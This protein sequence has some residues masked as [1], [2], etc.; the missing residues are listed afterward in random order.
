MAQSKGTNFSSANTPS[1]GCCKHPSSH[2]TPSTTTKLLSF[3]H[4]T[5]ASIPTVIAAIPQ[6]SQ[7]CLLP[8]HP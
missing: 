8:S 2:Q 5:V 6:P 7:P 1:L 4:S 3:L